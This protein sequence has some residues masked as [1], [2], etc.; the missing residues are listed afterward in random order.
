MN[1]TTDDIPRQSGKSAIVTGAGGLG[2]EIALA[3]AG[4]GA[5]VILA[6]RNEQSRSLTFFVLGLG[7][8]N[9]DFII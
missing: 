1:G 2:Y 6:G 5:D 9:L 3:L 7:R 4:A 8:S